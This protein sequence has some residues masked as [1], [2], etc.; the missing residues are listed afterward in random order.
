MTVTLPVRTPTPVDA[1]R[2]D[3]VLAAS[4]TLRLIGAGPAD[5]AA[6]EAQF[7]PSRPSADGPADLTIRYVEQLDVGHPFTYVGPGE[8]GYGPDGFVVLRGRFR[9][10]V[11]VLLPLADLGRPCEVVCEHGVGRVP[12]LVA[13]VNLA[14]LANGGVALHASAF[15]LDG[16][17]AIATGW[18]KGGKSEALL[19]FCQRGSRYVADEWVHLHADGRASG[20]H[21]P[22]RV[23]DWYLDQSP[24][25]RERVD[26]GDRRRLA[27]LRLASGAATVGRG[28][29]RL[30]TAID[31][32]RFVD[33]PVEVVAPHGRVDEPL[34]VGR[35]YLMSSTPG[36]DTTLRLVSGTEV[37]DRMAASLAYERAP[38]RDLVDAFRYALPSEAVADL[39]AVSGLERERLRRL[40]GD[41]PTAEVRHPYPASLDALHEAMASDPEHWR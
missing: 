41:V 22:V 19:A 11:R 12:H 34:P 20:I 5:R 10:Q 32:H 16:T 40:L 36:P 3:I 6:V 1:D 18:S 13:L 17:A 37:A 9:R 39:D 7:G 27:A 28:S 23:W 2:R 33:A 24:G 25:A 31:R 8:A 35:T 15:E 21:E 38:L 14:V 30:R 4:V 26:A 29:A